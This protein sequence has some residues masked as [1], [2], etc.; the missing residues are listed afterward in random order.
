MGFRITKFFNSNF[1]FLDPAT[2]FVGSK[3]FLV[4]SWLALSLA[5]IFFDGQIGKQIFFGTVLAL[6]L[7]VIIDEG[8]FKRVCTKRIRP[9]IVYP[10]EITAIGTHEGDSSFPSSHVASVL[11]ISTIYLYYFPQV[12]LLIVLFAL[13]MAF[14]R[15]HNG[16][17]YLSDIAAGIMLGIAYGLIAIY[18]VARIA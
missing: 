8:L 3:I 15:I 11:S 4:T 7:H 5:L 17:H 1:R 2:R 12:W 13:F 6:V 16:M 14:S 18:I 9:Y 10:E